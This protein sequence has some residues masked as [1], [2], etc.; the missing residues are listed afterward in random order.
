LENDKWENGN[1]EKLKNRKN[2]KWEN[3]KLEKWKT[4]K[5]ENGTMKNIEL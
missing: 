3:G 1:I 5:M 4:G 2:R